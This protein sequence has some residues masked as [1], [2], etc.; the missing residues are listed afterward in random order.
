M[1]KAIGYQG[2]TDEKTLVKAANDL[3]LADRAE[4]NE[5]IKRRYLQIGCIL[6]VAQQAGYVKAAGGFRQWVKGNLKCSHTHAYDCQNAWKRRDNLLD[7]MRWYESGDT[8]WKPKNG[9]GP[10]FARD[11][12]KAWETRNSPAPAKPPSRPSSGK[13][14]VAAAAM[15]K[16]RYTRLRDEHLK[17]AKFAKKEPV[18]LNSIEQEI[19]AEGETT[20]PVASVKPI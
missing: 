3:W 11:L 17:F 12:L 16:D 14:A 20:S 18:I 19:A 8:D 13:A 2:E 7:A 9:N 1:S 4:A 5:A 15:W 6:E 10:T